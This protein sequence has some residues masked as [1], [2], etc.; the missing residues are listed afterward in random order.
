M[1]P[2]VTSAPRVPL[3]QKRELASLTFPPVHGN[4]GSPALEDRLLIFS[5]DGAENPYL[6]ALDAAT[7]DVKWKTPR[8]TPAKSKFSFSTPLVIDVD[9][10]RQII[11]PTSGFVAACNASLPGIA[12]GV[13]G[14][15][16]RL[17]A[18]SMSSVV[19]VA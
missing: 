2:I 15:P 12:I 3:Q 10:K 11:S 7:G 1:P 9:G 13:G 8:Q 6:A 4:G 14:R 19:S 5:C 17:Y 16:A 18:A